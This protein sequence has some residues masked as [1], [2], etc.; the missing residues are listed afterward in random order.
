MKVLFTLLI[1][2]L[3]AFNLH[4][5]S[6]CP[7]QFKPSDFEE[8]IKVLDKY[9]IN[10]KVVRKWARLNDRPDIELATNRLEYWSKDIKRYILKYKDTNTDKV[11]ERFFKKDA[12]YFGDFGMLALFYKHMPNLA[13]INYT[14]YK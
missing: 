13:P 6:N 1:T 8:Y 14:K 4:A 3:L 9:R 7:D 2:C 11:C 10:L 5:Q 12:A